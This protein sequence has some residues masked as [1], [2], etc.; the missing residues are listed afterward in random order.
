MCISRSLM[1]YN[2]SEGDASRITTRKSLD[3][4]RIA[5]RQKFRMP[6]Q[7]TT[8]IPT[9]NHKDF[10]GNAI[11]SALAQ[12]GKAIKHHI[13]VADDGSSDGTAELVAKYASLHPGVITNISNPSNQGLSHTLNRRCIADAR[14]IHLTQ[15][16]KVMTFG[17]TT[18]SWR[19]KPASWRRIETAPWFS[20][21]SPSAHCLTARTDT[22]LGKPPSRNRNWAVMTSSPIP[23]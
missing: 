22:S 15:S 21:G 11:E 17:R 4:A 10:I 9:Y 1:I 3:D 8:I 23:A 12:N 7:V 16:W 19:S 13:I 5:L 14:Y 18:I 2:D 6:F 20:R